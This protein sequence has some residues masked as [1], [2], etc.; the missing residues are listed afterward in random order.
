MDSGEPFSLLCI[1]CNR[2]KKTGGEEL[3]F[4]EARKHNAVSPLERKQIAR[5]QPKTALIKDP[6]HFENSTRNLILPNGQ[7][8]E[9]HIRLIRQFNGQTVL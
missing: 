2:T 9:V 8:R 1:T 7:I 6:R 3:F 4:A 5:A